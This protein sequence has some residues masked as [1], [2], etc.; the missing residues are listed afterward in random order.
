LIETALFFLFLFI[1][2]PIKRNLEMK[3]TL[4]T[5]IL[6]QFSILQSFSQNIPEEFNSIPK[7]IESTVQIPFMARVADV[8]GVV[9]VRITVGIDSLPVNYEITKSLRPD[10]DLE[11]LRVVKLLN[12]RILRETLNG[13]KKVIIEVPFFNPNK[14]FYEKNYVLDY[15][16]KDQKPTNNEANIKFVRRYSVDTLTGIIKTN[17]EYFEY[18]KKDIVRSGFAFLKVDSSERHVPNFLENQTDTLRKIRFSAVT[19]STFPNIYFEV[20]ENG[21]IGSKQDANKIY[22][23]YPDGRIEHEHEVIETENTKNSVDIHWFANGQLAYVKKSSILKS[24]TLEK[25][26]AVWDTLGKQIV[27]DGNGFDE[28][29]EG[30][31]KNLS[32]HSGLLKDGV[33][34][35]KWTGKDVNNNVEYNE[36]YEKGKCLKGESYFGK[37][38]YYYTNP[39]ENA[40]FKTGMSGFA[41]HLMGNLKYPSAAQRANVSGTVYVQ[42][43]V[44]ID[45]TLRDYKVLKSIGF[46]CDEESVR[47]LQLS[48]GNWK[49][50]K[51]RG[52]AYRSRFTI[53][54]N[55][56]LGR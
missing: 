19:N 54:I 47:V 22:A 1:V 21:Q 10:C 32:I 55:Y 51:L 39:N 29:Y 27:K 48:S 41:N 3:K 7:F 16:D 49:P 45:G 23:Y 26:V 9:Q 25:Y 35:G 31:L 52:R 14:I 38:T 42:F 28:Y 4:F 12:I 50:G 5:L 6:L 15:Y 30:N 53:P 37:S 24:E 18:K 8:Q 34:E 43:V 33:K 2:Q 11:A 20:F 40:E 46:G 17:A 56:Q 13:K 44:D 36:I